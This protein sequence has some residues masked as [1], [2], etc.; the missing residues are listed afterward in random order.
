MPRAA[1]MQLTARHRAYWRRNLR[2]TLGLLVVWFAVSFVA[3]YFAVELNEFSFLDFP[4]GF[5]IFAQGA[6]I[7]FLLIIAIYVRAMNRLDREYGVAEK[8]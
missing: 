1:S 4:L 8:R 5:Y 2:L 6:L 3:G 7:A